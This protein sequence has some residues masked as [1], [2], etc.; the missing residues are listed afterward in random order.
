MSDKEWL[1]YYVYKMG[2][3]DVIPT[4]TRTHESECA[5]HAIGNQANAVSAGEI[6]LV[7]PPRD[8]PEL[9]YS[10]IDS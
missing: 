3:Y 7:F 4:K 10:A 5:V 8:L 1:Y 6:M 2:L 9:R